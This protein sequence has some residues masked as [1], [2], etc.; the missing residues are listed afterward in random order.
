MPALT[1]AKPYSQTC[2]VNI[3]TSAA[4]ASALPAQSALANVTANSCAPASTASPAGVST[5]RVQVISADAV[6]AASCLRPAPTWRATTGTTTP[7]RTPPATISKST[8][9]KLLAALYVSPRQ[10]S[11]TVFEKTTD[12]P[13][14]TRRAAKVRP[15]TPAATEAR[16]ALTRARW[17][18]RGVGGPGAR[19]GAAG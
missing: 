9:G 14:P 11:P 3:T 2:G 15:A 16:P 18:W 4:S 1:T 6:R 12:R 10:V 17:L 8:L 7:A 5:N 19:A 13:K